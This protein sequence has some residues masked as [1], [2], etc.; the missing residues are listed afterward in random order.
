MYVRNVLWQPGP[1]TK[2]PSERS[3]KTPSFRI[4]DFGRAEHLSDH[5]RE[6]QTK[7]VMREKVKL[8]EGYVEA[9]EKRAQKELLVEDF[10]Y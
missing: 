4:I 7:E 10:N 6:G 5:I 1:L 9:E 8:V 3:R 2:P